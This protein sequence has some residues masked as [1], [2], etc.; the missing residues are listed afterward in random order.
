MRPIS[1]T[2]RK[3]PGEE[4]GKPASMTS[5]SMRMSWLGDDELL[6]GVHGSAGGLLSVAQGGVEDMDLAWS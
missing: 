1:W 6:L 5:T 2:E 4:M 3:S